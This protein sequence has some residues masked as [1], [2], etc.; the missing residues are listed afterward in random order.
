MNEAIMTDTSTKERV[1][2]NP[3]VDMKEPGLYKVIYLNDEL[4]TME[5]VIETLLDIFNY[6]PKDAEDVTHKI[7]DDGQCVV[8]VYP[9]EIAEQKGVEVTVLARSRGFPLQVKIEKE[10]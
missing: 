1:K 10:E 5:F 6:T 2:I 3:R 4:T 9:Y 7:H 8:A